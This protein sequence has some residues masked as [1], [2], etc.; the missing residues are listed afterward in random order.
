MKRKLQ[1][2]ASVSVV[3][4]QSFLAPAQDES[5]INTHP[6]NCTPAKFSPAEKTDWLVDTA[7]AS[8]I[9]GMTVRNFRYAWHLAEVTGQNEPQ[10]G[11][12]RG[13]AGLSDDMQNLYHEVFVLLLSETES[14]PT[15]SI[16]IHAAS[17]STNSDPASPMFI[18]DPSSMPVAGDEAFLVIGVFG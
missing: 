4:F 10:P 15:N 12:A 7:N 13:L 3:L 5:T 8:D 18:I 6:Q 11:R 16:R 9:L 1:I 2:L 14:Q 17:V